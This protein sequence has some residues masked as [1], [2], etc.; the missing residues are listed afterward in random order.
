MKQSEIK[1]QN[2]PKGIL[3]ALAANNRV[4]G[5]FE[6][7]PDYMEGFKFEFHILAEY[8]FSPCPLSPAF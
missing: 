3:I 8:I 4:V 5:I 6:L 1:L 2:G 7:L